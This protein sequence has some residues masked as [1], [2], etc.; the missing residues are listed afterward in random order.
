[1]AT[2][3]G[4]N[5]TIIWPPHVPMLSYTAIATALLCTSLF[6]WQRY[7]VSMTPL[8]RSYMTEYVRSQAG[9]MFHAHEAYRL[10]YLGGGTAKPRL[11]FPAD[12][13]SGKTTLPSG[14][15]VPVALS[16][17]AIAQGHRSFFRGPE[18]KLADVSLHRWLRQMVFEDKGL[19]TG[20][21]ILL[22][23]RRK[24]TP[25]SA[26]LATFFAFVPTAKPPSCPAGPL[27]RPKSRDLPDFEA[28]S[29][30]PL[31]QLPSVVQ[32]G[33]AWLARLSGRQRQSQNPPQHACE[34]AP[35]QVALG[36]HH[37]VV[38]SVLD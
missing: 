10:L 8:Q 12:F 25:L 2:Q 37:P 28:I 1:M 23:R 4:R 30:T 33:F 3:W 35:R 17:L 29:Q 31:P 26:R 34:Q 21:S 18:Q 24:N 19:L 22:V 15:I 20:I 5:E 9:G 6:V 7:T 36:Q 38:P 27:P 11:A 16:E 32:I 14:Q 13:V